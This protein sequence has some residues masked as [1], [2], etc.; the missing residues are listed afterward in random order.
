MLISFAQVK[1]LC[2]HE[3]VLYYNIEE[4]KV[5]ESGDFAKEVQTLHDF[6]I[7]FVVNVTKVQTDSGAVFLEL[8]LDSTSDPSL[9]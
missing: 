6:S 4:L 8:D 3:V 2:D 5:Y 1:A 9:V 7:A